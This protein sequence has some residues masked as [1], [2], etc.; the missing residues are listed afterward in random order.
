MNYYRYSSAHPPLG[1]DTSKGITSE[2]AVIQAEQWYILPV[3]LRRLTG[4]YKGYFLAAIAFSLI[5]EAVWAQSPPSI[6]GTWK[7]VAFENHNA[8]GSVLHF[9]AP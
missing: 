1:R 6:I 5:V 4:N 3:F 7:L 8:D 2:C 9:E